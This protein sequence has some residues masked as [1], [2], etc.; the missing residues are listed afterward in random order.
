MHN[1]FR[2]EIWLIIKKTKFNH[3]NLT[4]N[5]YIDTFWVQNEFI[6]FNDFVKF[7]KN[8]WL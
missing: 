8:L 5:Q 4:P 3:K 2:I 6:E 1:D 7:G